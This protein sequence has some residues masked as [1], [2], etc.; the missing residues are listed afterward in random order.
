MIQ[1]QG[2]A[3]GRQSHLDLFSQLLTCRRILGNMIHEKK[4]N[5]Y[6]WRWIKEIDILSGKGGS[7]CF[8]DED[9]KCTGPVERMSLKE[10][11]SDAVAHSLDIIVGRFDDDVVV[12]RLGGCV[13]QKV[14]KESNKITNRSTNVYI[15]ATPIPQYSEKRNGAWIDV[16]DHRQRKT[17]I[18]FC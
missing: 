16:G 9:D 4:S 2:R 18:P 5:L 14:S 1:R 12:A 15:W 7:W 17:K 8:D 6:K 10:A 3:D 13:T 11:S